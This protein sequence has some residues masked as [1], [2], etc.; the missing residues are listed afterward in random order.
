MK[1]TLRLAAPCLGIAALLLASNSG[2]AND[3]QEAGATTETKDAGTLTTPNSMES[4]GVVDEEAGMTGDTS[5]Q[6]KPTEQQKMAMKSELA[7]HVVVIESS[8]ESAK[9]QLAGIRAQ[10]ELSEDQQKHPIEQIRLHTRELRDDLKM[11]M[12]HQTRLQSGVKKY[13]Q[14]AQSGEFR[15]VSSSLSEVNRGVQSWETKSKSTAY[16]NNKDQVKQDLDTFEKQL[17]SAIS[18]AK[19][20]GSKQF[21][22]PSVG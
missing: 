17:D 1:N 10:Y 4:P 18:N 21:E 7:P 12:D 8:L 22:A 9:D 16:W 15:Q 13:P 2:W 19:S 20:F 3:D 6:Q 5:S 11:A 14:V